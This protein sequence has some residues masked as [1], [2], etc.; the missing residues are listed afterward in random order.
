[1]G[2]RHGKNSRQFFQTLFSDLLGLLSG[3]FL[4]L[5]VG[6]R[7]AD[8]AQRLSIGDR[9]RPPLLFVVSRDEWGSHFSAK[10]TEPPSH[11]QSTARLPGSGLAIAFVGES[12]EIGPQQFVFRKT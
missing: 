9:F 12:K 4:E 6:P 8:R 10:K 11:L 5:S 7:C 1:M 3:V 2:E